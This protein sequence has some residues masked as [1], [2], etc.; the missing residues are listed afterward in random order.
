MLPSTERTLLID[1]LRNLG[2]DIIARN[3]WA[4]IDAL[5]KMG[6]WD[7]LL[8]DHDLA[9]YENDGTE[10]TGYSIMCWLEQNPQYRPRE[11]QFVTSNPVGRNKME[12]VRKRLYGE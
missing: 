5:T 3:Y 4:G 7:L 1:D 12:V 2:A 6:P 11:I 9:S 10:R 8:L